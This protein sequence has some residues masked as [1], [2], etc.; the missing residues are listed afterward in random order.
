MYESP[1]MEDKRKL[2]RVKSGMWQQSGTYK[3][4]L[5]S[6][7]APHF[8]WLVQDRHLKVAEVESGRA[9]PSKHDSLA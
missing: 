3:Q 1:F 6:S 8:I 5:S 4:L 7:G 2:I 9:L